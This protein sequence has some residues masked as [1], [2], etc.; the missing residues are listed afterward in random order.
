[1]LKLSDEDRLS[2][3][4][5]FNN[6]VANMGEIKRLLAKYGFNYSHGL[7]KMGEKYFEKLVKTFLKERG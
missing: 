6:M 4:G 5:N 3:Q 1:M 2:L 7:V